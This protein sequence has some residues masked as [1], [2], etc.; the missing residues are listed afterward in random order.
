MFWIVQAYWKFLSSTQN[1][2]TSSSTNSAALFSAAPQM[3]L[4]LLG[5][6]VP[7]TSDSTPRMVNAFVHTKNAN[8]SVNLPYDTSFSSAKCPVGVTRSVHRLDVLYSE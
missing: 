4:L 6:A 7:C 5:M 1:T 8:S 3:M 2:S